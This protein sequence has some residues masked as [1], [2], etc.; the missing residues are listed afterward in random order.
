MQIFVTDKSGDSMSIDIAPNATIQ[1]LK[2]EI[3]RANP[4]LPAERQV[5]IFQGV[6]MK[7]K[8]KLS[9]SKIV[10]DC[11]LRVVLEG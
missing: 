10:R 2:E 3:A 9:E 6:Y 1:D 7:N 4:E 11:T 5:L 8:F